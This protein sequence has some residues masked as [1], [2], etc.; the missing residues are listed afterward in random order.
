MSPPNSVKP[1]TKATVSG[2]QEVDRLGRAINPELNNISHE[3]QAFVGRSRPIPNE[4]WQPLGG[5]A[6]GLVDKLERQRGA[7]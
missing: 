5:I 7:K 4:H 2:L 1:A 3:S 6:H